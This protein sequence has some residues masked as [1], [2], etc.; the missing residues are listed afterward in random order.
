M[1]SVTYTYTVKKNKVSRRI[2]EGTKSISDLNPPLE[3]LKPLAKIYLPSFEK[4]FLKN[5]IF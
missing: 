1:C 2:R 5:S 4:P 3:K